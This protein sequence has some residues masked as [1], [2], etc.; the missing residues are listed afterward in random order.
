M[1]LHHRDNEFWC[2]SITH[3]LNDG[4][5]IHIKQTVKIIHYSVILLLIIV[6]DNQAALLGQDVI[7][8]NQEG[9]PISC[10][11]SCS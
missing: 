4:E 9:F 6:V 10:S 8:E 11:S 5:Y 7:K 2:L 1:K 3:T